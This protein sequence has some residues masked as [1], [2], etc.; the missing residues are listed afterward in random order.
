MQHT[1]APSTAPRTWRSVWNGSEY[2]LMFRNQVMSTRT[3]RM[4]R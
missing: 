4:A 3:V 1:E 2:Q